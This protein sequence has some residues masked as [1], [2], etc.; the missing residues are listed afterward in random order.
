MHPRQACEALAQM[1]RKGSG[2]WL[3]DAV[4]RKG[5]MLCTSDKALDRIAH[6][7]PHLPR[8]VLASWLKMNPVLH[9]EN[10]RLYTHGQAEPQPE[11]LP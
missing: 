10:E 5:N 9:L 2:A 6:E 1:M 11:H 4:V 7:Q 3:V 8:L